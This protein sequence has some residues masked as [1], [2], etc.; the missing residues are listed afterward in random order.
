MSKLNSIDRCEGLQSIA[1]FDGI[2]CEVVVKLRNHLQTYSFGFAQS[3]KN[4]RRGMVALADCEAITYTKIRDFQLTSR[5]PVYSISYVRCLPIQQVCGLNPI[6]MFSEF[7]KRTQCVFYFLFPGQQA[8]EDFYS[9][10]QQGLLPV[11]GLKSVGDVL[12]SL[13]MRDQHPFNSEL[14]RPKCELHIVLMANGILLLSHGGHNDCSRC[15]GYGE[16]AGQQSLKIIKV[17]PETTRFIPTNEGQHAFNT[18]DL[19][20]ATNQLSSWL[21]GYQ[22]YAEDQ[23]KYAC[24]NPRHRFASAALVLHLAPASVEPLPAPIVDRDWQEGKAA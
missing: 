9:L 18:V 1:Q 15:R 10:K 22:N 3:L 17:S 21:K 23:R 6:L 12:Q 5:Q 16:K 13:E 24:R 11:G 8:V 14:I 2:S 19:V 4:L 20:S 7:D